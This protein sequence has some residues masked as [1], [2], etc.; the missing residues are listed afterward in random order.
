M[1]LL[2]LFSMR[3]FAFVVLVLGM[4]V[5]VV[6][7]NGS[8]VEVFGYG[9]LE[10]F[11]LN[12][13]VSVSGEVVS[14]KIIYSGKWVLVLDIENSENSLALVSNETSSSE[15]EL[16]CSCEGGFLGEEVNVVGVVGEY[17]EKKQIEVLKIQIV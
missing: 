7:L 8:P 14:E 12:Q 4:F 13:R 5:L 1:F 17:N 2:L 6:L 3:R 15:I 11:E 10:S 16:V 9:N